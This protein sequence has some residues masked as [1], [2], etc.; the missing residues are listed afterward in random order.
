MKARE[1]GT[2]GGAVGGSSNKEAGRY[3]LKGVPRPVL[4]VQKN[5][6]FPEGN[7]KPLS[8]LCPTQELHV[9]QGDGP[10]G[11]LLSVQA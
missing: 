5:P 11:K 9:G 7:Y 1:S 6:T 2:A 4:K 10:A 3:I 8:P